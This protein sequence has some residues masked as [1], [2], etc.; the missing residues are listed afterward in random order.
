MRKRHLSRLVTGALV[1]VLLMTDAAA[2]LP[3]SAPHGVH[4]AF[5][6]PNIIAGLFRTGAALHRRNEIYREAGATAAELNAYYDR[7]IEET[8]RQRQEM[9]SKA[10]RGETSPRFVRSYVRIEAALEAERDAAIAMVEAEKNQ[11]RRDFNRTLG[12]E[13][14]NTLIASP[15]GQ[16]ILGRVRE[17]IA[18]TREAAIAVQAAAEEGRPIEALADALA[19]KVGDIPI[20]QEAARQLGS[21]AGHRLDR[22]LGGVLTKIERAVDNVQAGMG[23]ALGTLDDLDAAVAEYDEEERQPVSLV[24]DESLVGAVVPVDRANAAASVAASAYA[25]AAQA[26]GALKPGTS[27]GAMRDRIRG[28]LLDERVE[29][30]RTAVS[31]GGVG[32]IYCTAVGQGEYEVAAKALGQAPVTARDP[33]RAAYLVCYDIETGAPQYAKMFAADEQEDATGEGEG[34]TA[35]PE[36]AEEPTAPPPARGGIPAGTY[37]GTTTYPR[38][39]E[40]IGLR[41]G[42]GGETAENEVAITVAEDGTVTGSLR[43]RHVGGTYTRDTADG[44]CSGNWHTLV[45]GSFAGQLTGERGTIE[46]TQTWACH[47]TGSCGTE[48]SCDD[49]PVK[50]QVEVEVSGDEMTGTVRPVPPEGEEVGQDVIDALTWTFTATRE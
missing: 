44:Q 3:R 32:K 14:V 2:L 30:I 7:L 35:T 4:A 33:E 41:S 16:R 5:P 15:G 29:G 10:A 19:D 31:E 46:S 12:R 38:V 39:L 1:V 26:A 34:A 17:T 40:T 21:A 49:E 36:E 50:S 28:A 8:G 13:I 22:A 20:V 47:T 23:E 48:G 42:D 6:G 9:I 45:E 43:V 18:R 11:A 27:R 25:G 24:E 37:V